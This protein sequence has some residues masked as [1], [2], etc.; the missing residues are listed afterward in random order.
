MKKNNC[1]LSVIC[2]VYNEVEHIEKLLRFFVQAKP[3]S[4]ELFLVDGGSTD[5]TI[6]ILEKWAT[7]HSNVFVLYNEQRYVPYA[8]NM[9]IPLCSGDYIVRL[10]AHTEYKADYF[11]Q[12][13]LAFQ[14]SK[15]DIVG[16]P[17][18]TKREGVC[19][20]IAYAINTSLGVGDSKVHQDDYEGFTDSVTFG[21]WRRSIFSVTG[22]FDTHLR[23]NQDDEFHYR[24]K[25]MG[26][27]IYQSPTI[28]L[29]YYP[30][31]TLGALFRQYFQ[32]G[33]YKPLVLRKVPDEIKWRHLIP[34]FFVLYLL[35]LPLLLSLHVVFVFPLCL[36]LLLVLYYSFFNDLPWRAKMRC[37]LVYPVLHISYGS[38][39]LL[40]LGK[41]W[42]RK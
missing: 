22:L 2:P 17:T 28:Y 10:D 35:M 38:G 20:A 5:G 42:K 9:A 3:E 30:R 26:F 34:F 37:L 18:R 11:E 39:F 19:Q 36:Y 8:L 33:L 7:R 23:R 12:I 15:A 24:A 29:S 14:K 32:Y 25:S 27:K 41:L 16:G 4:K 31:K 40:G 13:L 1:L 6:E 21:A